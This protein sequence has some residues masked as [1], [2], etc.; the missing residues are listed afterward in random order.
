M[1]KI[2]VYIPLIF[3]RKVRAPIP[4]SFHKNQFN[5]HLLREFFWPAKDGEHW[6]LIFT[7]SDSVAFKPKP[8]F[9]CCSQFHRTIGIHSLPS[10][11][12]SN[13]LNWY[14]QTTGYID[15]GVLGFPLSSSSKRSQT[16]RK[17]NLGTEVTSL[18]LMA[19]AQLGVLLSCEPT[20]FFI[21]RNG[22]EFL[23]EVQVR[24]RI[25]DVDVIWTKAVILA[26]VFQMWRQ[27]EGGGKAPI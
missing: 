18:V 4:W 19:G 16:K 2:L 5:L 1:T 6:L 21:G 26:I 13:V 24:R 27:V 7:G 23:C 20:P 9:A 11:S 25:T 3:L 10:I 8:S 15:R 22:L 17:N 14:F 12:T